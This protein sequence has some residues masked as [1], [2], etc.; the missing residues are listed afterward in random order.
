MMIGLLIVVAAPVLLVD[1]PPLLDYPNHLARAVALAAAGTDM[2]AAQI[3]KPRWAIIPNLGGDLVLIFLLQ[4]LPPLAAGQTFLI[5]VLATM[6][7]GVIVYARVVFGRWTAWS[8]AS[9]VAAYGGLFLMGFLN[10]CLA[11]GLALVIA[12]GWTAQR[13]DRPKLAIAGAA[14][15]IV[16]VW[17]CHIAGALLCVMLIIAREVTSFTGQR[18]AILTPREVR[19][20]LFAVALVCLPVILL[21]FTADISAAETKARWAWDSKLL[22][23]FLPAAAY[24]PLVDSVV[25]LVLGATLVLSAL[26]RRLD[27]DRAGAAV[28]LACLLIYVAAPFAAKSGTWLD[29]RFVAMAWLLLFACLA[30]RFEG[31]AGRV[32]IAATFGAVALKVGSIGLAWT[33]AEPEI[34]QVRAALTCVPPLSRVLVARTKGSSKD[35]RHRKLLFVPVYSHLGALALIDRGAFWP[36]MF[37]R[38]GQHP[39]AVRP[40]YEALAGPIARL[41]VVEE[42]LITGEAPEFSNRLTLDAARFDFLLLLDASKQLAPLPPALQVECDAGYAKLFRIQPDP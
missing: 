36:S 22:R 40:P 21:Y 35:P 20:R 6:V 16:V 30:P 37:T 3:Y 17:F 19:R 11:T 31:L 38:M 1:L 23:A 27:V 41:P 34:A 14:A 33:R 10:F 39:I 32:A 8:F 28:A 15:G 13:R 25:A 4:F 29:V 26:A 18:S 9:P 5:L 24:Y 12:A 42:L 2:P 7:G